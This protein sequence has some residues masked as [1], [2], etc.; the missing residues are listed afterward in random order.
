VH[1][2]SCDIVAEGAVSSDN[3]K[4]LI[5]R[6]LQLTLRDMLLSE[7]HA[8]LQIRRL[9]HDTRLQL[10]ESRER[11]GG[12]RQIGDQLTVLAD[13]G[14]RSGLHVVRMLA[15]GA[16]V[17]LLGRASV[18]ALVA[19]GKLGVRQLLEIVAKEMRVAMTRTGAARVSELSRSNLATAG[20]T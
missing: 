8:R 7:F 9:S 17:M 13:S 20:R 4:Q 16:K 1:H 12:P 6:S 18:C 11:C 2:A 14:A 10:R 19:G 15:S 3:F 5:Q